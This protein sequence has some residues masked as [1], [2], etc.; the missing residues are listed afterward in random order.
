MFKVQDFP[1]INKVDDEKE[2]MRLLIDGGPVAVCMDTDES[3]VSFRGVSAVCFFS[4]N[5][6]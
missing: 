6:Y 4:F 1:I 2:L 3:F 5:I